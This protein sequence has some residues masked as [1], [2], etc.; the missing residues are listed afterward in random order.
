ME[1]VSA[2]VWTDLKIT[3]MSKRNQT[4]R[5][6]NMWFHLC[7]ILEQVNLNYVKFSNNRWLRNCGW[8]LTG[9]ACN[10]T[11]W[12]MDMLDLMIVLWVTQGYALNYKQKRYTFHCIISL[13]I[14][15]IS[16]YNKWKYKS[17]KRI[18]LFLSIDFQDTLI[19]ILFNAI[20]QY[21]VGFFWRPKIADSINDLHIIK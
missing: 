3:V 15:Y 14:T 21:E 18:S 11:L 8:E 19:R 10:S 1:H 4:K 9:T 2:I 12:K 5:E 16:I 13:F 7:E 20:L 6:Y 17:K